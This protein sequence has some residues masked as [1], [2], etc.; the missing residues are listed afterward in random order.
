[1]HQRCMVFRQAGGCIWPISQPAKHAPV[2]R[3]R[4]DRCRAAAAAAAS[5]PLPW[6]EPS[7]GA[8]VAFLEPKVLPTG[9]PTCAR[10]PEAATIEVVDRSCSLRGPLPGHGSLSQSGEC[11]GWPSA[12][13]GHCEQAGLVSLWDSPGATAPLPDARCSPV[14]VLLGP[15]MEESPAHP[16]SATVS[17][18]GPNLLQSGSHAQ[19]YIYAATYTAHHHV[20]RPPTAGG[21]RRAARP[22]PCGLRC[23][24][25]T[26]A[27]LTVTALL[28]WC[29]GK[30]AGPAAAVEWAASGQCGAAVGRLL[31]F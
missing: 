6:L 22:P 7:R 13:G 3:C 9:R 27:V 4:Q 12:T 29:A 2:R 5:G 10:R 28:G 15:E 31:A 18:G 14:H 11:D 8:R 17:A 26:S 19:K 21:P 25:R 1:M 20:E 16:P 23:R 30:N 24:D